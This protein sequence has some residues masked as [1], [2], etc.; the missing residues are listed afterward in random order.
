MLNL[1]IVMYCAKFLSFSESFCCQQYLV[2]LVGVCLGLQVAVIEFAR[3][4]I[5]WKG[6]LFDMKPC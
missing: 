4:I 1:F 3:N 5:G 2:Y 6:D